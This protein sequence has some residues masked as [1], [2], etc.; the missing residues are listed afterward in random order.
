LRGC[1]VEAVGEVV[2]G[3]GGEAVLVLDYYHLMGVKG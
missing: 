2:L 3:F 1:G